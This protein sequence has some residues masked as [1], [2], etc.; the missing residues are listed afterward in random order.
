MFF[1]AH[2]PS[3][4]VGCGCCSPLDW[5]Q[6]DLRFEGRLH[7]LQKSAESSSGGQS[8]V[9]THFAAHIDSG[10]HRLLSLSFPP[11][12]L[13]VDKCRRWLQRYS[14]RL[15]TLYPR[16]WDLPD[17]PLVKPIEVIDGYE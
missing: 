2:L 11:P 14:K 4:E 6:L 15:P 5:S 10:D 12:R 13:P 16:D 7:L 9:W 3:E 1:S 17:L 8:M